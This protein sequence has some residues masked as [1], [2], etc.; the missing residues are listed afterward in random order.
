MRLFYLPLEPY[1]ERYTWF[2]SCVG[3]WTEDHFRQCS[4]PFTRIDG[5]TLGTKINTGVV[6]DAYGRSFFAMSQLCTLVEMIQ[7]GGVKDGDVIYTEDFWHPGIESLFYIRELSGIKFKIGTFLHAQSVDEWDFTYSMRSWMRP[8][9]SGY[10]LGYDF[11]FVTS[12]MLRQQCL[13][14]GIFGNIIKVGLPYNSH[15]LLEQLFEKGYRIPKKEPFVLFSSR[16]DKEKDPDF[17]L[18][19]VEKCPNI[20][21]KLVKPREKLSNDPVLEQK[22]LELEKT[23]KNLEIV[24][25]SD[26]MAYYSLLGRAK[27]QINCAH[28]DWVS[29]TLLEA[30]TFRCQ[31][32]YPIWRDFPLELNGFNDSL[33]I[34]GD[35]ENCSGKLQGLMKE[36][37][38]PRLAEVVR[39]HDLSW[40]RYLEHM[41]FA[42][43]CK[44]REEG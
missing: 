36:E 33:Y 21:F 8:I 25:T 23:A 13:Q 5:K 2:M 6:L 22:A 31:P 39:R 27:V 12:E 40:P 7:K 30:I 24:D 42:S 11:I 18:K 44:V 3:G 34:K 14:G 17:F 29:W 41:G 38:D 26:K 15:R 35:L 32:L 10:A 16:F 28:Q 9:E 4:I 1:Q 20:Q 19:L 43:T 37:F